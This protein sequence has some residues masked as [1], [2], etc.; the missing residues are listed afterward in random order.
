MSYWVYG[1][2]M[3]SSKRMLPVGDGSLVTNLMF[4]NQYPDDQI[5]KV[6]EKLNKDN[7]EYMFEKRKVPAK[8]SLWVL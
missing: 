1:K 6:V 5:D 7:E 2:K 4:A 3:G 8:Q